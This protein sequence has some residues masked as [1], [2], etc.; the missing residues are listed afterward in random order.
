VRD[1]GPVE[2][3]LSD[4]DEREVTSGV[5]LGRR[6]VRERLVMVAVVLPVEGLQAP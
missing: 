2:G 6:E 1:P 5:D 4:G 3:L